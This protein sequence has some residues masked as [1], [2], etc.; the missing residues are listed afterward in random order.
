MDRCLAVS[1]RGVQVAIVAIRQLEAWTDGT[2]AITLISV[3]MP[4][5]NRSS[6][7]TTG[8]RPAAINGQC[9]SEPLIPTDDA[10]IDQVSCRDL[11]QPILAKTRPICAS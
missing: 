6:T 3:F 8:G 2:I 5:P 1:L 10:E 7:S 11:L 9:M 4:L